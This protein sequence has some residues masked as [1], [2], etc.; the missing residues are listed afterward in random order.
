MKQT[1]GSAWLDTLCG[2]TWTCASMKRWLFGD[3]KNLSLQGWKGANDR[4]CAVMQGNYR[5]SCISD[6]KL[7][8]RFLTSLLRL[9]LRRS[10]FAWSCLD[11]LMNFLCAGAWKSKAEFFLEAELINVTPNFESW[12]PPWVELMI[13][14]ML[15]GLCSG[16]YAPVMLSTSGRSGNRRLALCL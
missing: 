3:A 1:D 14:F 12:E 8:P 10:R 4:G 11:Y 9:C 2:E 5:E 13:M 16:A 6:G 7:R 15:W